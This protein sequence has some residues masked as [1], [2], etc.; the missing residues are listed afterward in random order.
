MPCDF[1][2]NIQADTANHDYQQQK[3]IYFKKFLVGSEDSEL[4]SLQEL[5]ILG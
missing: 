5:M 1:K 2:E 4:F 3:Q